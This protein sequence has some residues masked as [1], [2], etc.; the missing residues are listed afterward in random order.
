VLP[1]RLP[2]LPEFYEELVTTQRAIYRKHLGFGALRE[3]AHFSPALLRA[4]PI[5][6]RSLFK[7]NSVY[8]PDS[9]SPSCK[10]GRV[11]DRAAAAA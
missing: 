3:V 8:R 5:S 11:R 1:T 2:R 7:L 6:V 9:C 10:A 4:G